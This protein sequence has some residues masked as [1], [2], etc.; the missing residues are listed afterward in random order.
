MS[1]MITIERILEQ[2]DVDAALYLLQRM[3]RLEDTVL[4]DRRNQLE[5]LEKK[6]SRKKRITDEEREAIVYTYRE[7]V[8]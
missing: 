6:L 8:G 2:R 7:V 5:D 1:K 3:L 4:H